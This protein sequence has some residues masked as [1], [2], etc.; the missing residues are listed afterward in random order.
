[1]KNFN[2]SDIILFFSFA[3]ICICAVLFVRIKLPQGKKAVISVNNNEIGCYSLYENKEII[4]DGNKVI[5]ENGVA[6][7][8]SA[9]CP[10]KICERHAAIHKKG[11]IIVC[12]PHKVIVE[13]R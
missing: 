3:A 1:M 7:M 10:L 11:E 2:K 9:D 8:Q 6:K 5:I 13:I 12:L 4:L